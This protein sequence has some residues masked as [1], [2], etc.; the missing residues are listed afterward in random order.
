LEHKGTVR[1]QQFAAL[2]EILIEKT[3]ADRFDHLD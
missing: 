1:P 2:L 3:M